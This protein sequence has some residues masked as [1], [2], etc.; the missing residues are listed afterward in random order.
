MDEP[1]ESARDEMWD[2]PA[3]IEVRVGQEERVDI[4]WVVREGKAVT[5]DLVRTSLEHPAIDEYA[6]V[7]RVEEVLGA[8]DGRRAAKEG[9]L[10]ARAILAASMFGPLLRGEKVTLRPA[11][12]NDAEHFVRWFADMEV[13]RYLNRRLAVTLEQEREYL[14][15][16]GESKEDVWWMIDAEAKPIGTTG[17]HRINWLDANGTT[18]IMIGEKDCWRKGYATEAMRLRTRYAFHELNLHK[19]MTEVDAENEASRKAL[20][21][22]GYR[23]VGIRREQSFREGTWK[24]RWLGEV[25]RADWEKIQGSVG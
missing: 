8:G 22:N 7:A 16:I 9:K 5:H 13:T 1:A 6:R 17:V 18:G 10:H 2:E 19:L 24:D 20:E 3:V 23:S 15:K 21:R 14:K 4:L 25:L 12:E 11:R